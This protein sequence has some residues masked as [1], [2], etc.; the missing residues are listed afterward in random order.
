MAEQQPSVGR[1]VHY[2]SY[3][4]PEPGPP[5]PGPGPQPP[6]PAPV[7]DDADAALATAMQEW[8]KAKGLAR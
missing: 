6:V 4:T 2:T 7:V 8:L 5:P 1:I 3:G